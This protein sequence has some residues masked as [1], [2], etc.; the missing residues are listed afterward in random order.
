M[1]ELPN[2]R[3]QLPAL[4]F[5]ERRIVRTLWGS[6]Q[7]MRGPLGSREESWWRA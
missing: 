6:P 5:K 3:V 1:P 2:K 7:L 4:H